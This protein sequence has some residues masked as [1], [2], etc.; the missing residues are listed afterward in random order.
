LSGKQSGDLQYQGQQLPFGCC[1]TLWDAPEGSADAD[2]LEVL[3]MLVEVY[4]KATYPCGSSRLDAR[5]L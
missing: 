2:Q 3:A 1:H 4:E 5:L